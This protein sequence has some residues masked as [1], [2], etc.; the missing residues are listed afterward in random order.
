MII[1]TI[2]FAPKLFHDVIIANFLS[3]ISNMSPLCNICCRPMKL[4]IITQRL[5]TVSSVLAIPNKKALLFHSFNICI[6]CLQLTSRDTYP[7]KYEYRWTVS[8]MPTPP[9]LK[10]IIE[11]ITLF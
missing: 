6:H 5:H 7:G 4:I 1:C 9:N 2:S 10:S 3:L 11:T 8:F